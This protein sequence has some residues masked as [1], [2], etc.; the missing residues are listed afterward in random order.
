MMTSPGFNPFAMLTD[1]V[2]VL[3]AM[4]ASPALS[5]LSARVFRPLELGGALIPRDA[6]LAAYDAAVEIDDLE[7]GPS[8]L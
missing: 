2:S 6:D 3:Q 1:P 4:Q 5:S 8:E 7:L